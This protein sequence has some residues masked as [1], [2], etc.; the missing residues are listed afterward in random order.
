[1]IDQKDAE[2]MKKGGEAAATLKKRDEKI[3]ADLLEY[4]KK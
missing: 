2:E 4:N 1:M 3:A